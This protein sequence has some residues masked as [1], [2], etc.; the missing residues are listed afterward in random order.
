MH[1]AKATGAGR[2]A[3]TGG[4]NTS[5]RRS[6]SAEDQDPPRLP[7]ARDLRADEASPQRK[8]K[9]PQ[10]PAPPRVLFLSGSP[11]HSGVLSA[12]RSVEHD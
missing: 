3:T 12:E 6:A 2:T 5:S 10:T 7:G 4:T 1:K 8:D 11:D 9:A